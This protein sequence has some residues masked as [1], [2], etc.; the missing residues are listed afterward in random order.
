[1]S[2]R[3]VDLDS[4]AFLSTLRDLIVDA[5][6]GRKAGTNGPKDL[7]MDRR[8][9]VLI[10]HHAVAGDRVTFELRAVSFGAP[11]A[12]GKNMRR[13]FLERDP[14]PASRHEMSLSGFKDIRFR[15]GAPK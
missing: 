6:F 7:G 1:M 11:D 9:G 5:A 15:K 12:T 14:F 10:Q 3:P 4:H 2:D 8:E 13:I